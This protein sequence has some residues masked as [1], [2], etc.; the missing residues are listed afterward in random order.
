MSNDASFGK[1]PSLSAFLESYKA[2]DKKKT[3][4]PILTGPPSVTAKKIKKVQAKPADVVEVEAVL[5]VHEP[6]DSDPAGGKHIRLRVAVT[7]ILANAAG[8]KADVLDAKATGRDVFVAI[9]IGDSM[10]ILEPVKGL[11]VSAALHLKGQWIT[12][13]KAQAHG[14]VKMSVLHFTHHPVG[15]TCTPIKCYA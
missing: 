2:A 14:G 8:V 3:L 10:G 6:D 5:H 11:T 4:K 15:F 13:Q 7:K 1:F 12:R 9:R